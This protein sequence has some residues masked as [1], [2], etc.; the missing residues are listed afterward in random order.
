[1][2][3]PELQPQIQTSETAVE[4]GFI[5]I[6][7]LFAHSFLSPILH[8]L[9]FS[10]GFLKTFLLSKTDWKDDCFLVTLNCTTPEK[11]GVYILL[12]DKMSSWPHLQ[13]DIKIKSW[14]F[15][16]CKMLRPFKIITKLSFLE[17][18]ILFSWIILDTGNKQSGLSLGI[19]WDQHIVHLAYSW[20]YGEHHLG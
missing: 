9:L 19:H 1:M 6:I 14:I 7:H 2:K 13:K 10:F 17:I 12:P 8:W 11:W 18:K 16:E 3:P 5:W 20:I 4:V 15:S